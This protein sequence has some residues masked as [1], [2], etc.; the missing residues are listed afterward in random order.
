MPRL[1][2]PP[3]SIAVANTSLAGVGTFAFAALAMHAVRDDL[4]WTRA[5]LSFYLV[6]EHGA[7]LKASY[8]GLALA[9]LLVGLQF[10]H[11]LRPGARSDLAPWLFGTSALAV[12]FTAFF[13]THLPG[14]PGTTGGYVHGVAAP[15]A[16][17]TV[18]F[19]MLLQSWYLR[20]DPAWRHRFAVAF[21]IALA[22]FAGLWVHALVSDWPRGLTQRGV[23]VLIVAWLLLASTWLRAAARDQRARADSTVS[24][25]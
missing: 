15:I 6:G 25:S 13:E 11:A 14:L 16:F 2:P 21:A 7:W 22:T 18:S 5:P 9:L 1:L 20:M 10:R 24:S 17:L 19:G 3:H 12:L 8:V 23:I 4:V